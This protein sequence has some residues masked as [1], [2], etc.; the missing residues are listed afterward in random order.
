MLERH[1]AL[2]LRAA[3]ELVRAPG[4]PEALRPLQ[5]EHVVVPAASLQRHPLEHGL[6]HAE[7]VGP[8]ALAAHGVGKVA[9]EEHDGRRLNLVREL[10]DGGG[11]AP[12]VG[13]DDDVRGGRVGGQPRHGRRVGV[14]VHGRAVREP[15]ALAGHKAGHRGRVD[16]TGV[17]KVGG[18]VRGRRA[19][20]VDGVR[21]RSPGD[22][23]L[24]A[25][26]LLVGDRRVPALGAADPHEAQ[27]V[28]APGEGQVRLLWKRGRRVQQERQGRKPD[29]TRRP[30]RES[31]GHARLRF[32][33]RVHARRTR[34]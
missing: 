34:A 9:G 31:R 7:P 29:G 23:L 4:R 3:V 16:L 22:A 11:G 13:Q 10:V 14:A 8:Q 33:G 26:G 1:P 15:H 28:D 27:L 30:C 12:H 20:L 21:P 6:H 19:Q 17:L 32:V 18:L 5:L 24:R 2:A 25:P